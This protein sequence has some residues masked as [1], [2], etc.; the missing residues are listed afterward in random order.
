M[1]CDESSATAPTAG[2]PATVAAEVEAAGISVLRVPAVDGGWE[3]GGALNGDCAGVGAELAVAGGTGAGGVAIGD[4]AAGGALS[5]SVSSEAAAF[6]FFFL[7]E[8]RSC[9]WALCFTRNEAVTLRFGPSEIWSKEPSY[10]DPTQSAR[11]AR[12]RDASLVPPRLR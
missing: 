9:S 3:K 7:R 2:T 1:T 6:F 10:A 8:I 12:A 5:R 11:R 4:G